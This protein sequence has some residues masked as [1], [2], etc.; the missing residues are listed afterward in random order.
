MT[1]LEAA[2]ELAADGE[3]MTLYTEDHKE[4]VAAFKEKRDPVFRGR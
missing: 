3:A 4:A 1:A 2:L